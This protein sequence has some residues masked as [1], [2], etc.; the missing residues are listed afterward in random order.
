MDRDRDED[1]GIPSETEE[2][3]RQ[4]ET[5]TKEMRGGNDP[6]GLFR[7]VEAGQDGH[8][9]ECINVYSFS[10]A[11]ALLSRSAE[12]ERCRDHVSA[13]GESAALQRHVGGF[14]SR[15][16]GGLTPAGVF[17]QVGLQSGAASGGFH[18]EGCLAGG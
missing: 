8:R 17:L 9:K 7:G 6:C 1:E 15:W 10:C 3:K 12:A 16:R 5:K 18:H 4:L 14:E 11:F 2:D 13:G